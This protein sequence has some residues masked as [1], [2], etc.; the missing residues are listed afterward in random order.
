LRHTPNIQIGDTNQATMKTLRLAILV[1]LVGLAHT[2]AADTTPQPLPFSQS[3][4]STSQITTDD[5][6]S[7]VAGITGYRGDAAGTGVVDP[8]A[9]LE[10]RSATIDVNANQT[11]PDSFTTGGVT[12]FEAG[13][14]VASS[15]IALTG[16]GNADAPHI[17]V[18]LDTTGVVGV[19]VQYDILDLE[20]GDSAAQ[21]VALQYRVG[22]TGSF[23]NVPGGLVADATDPV[24]A[25][26]VT[27]VNVVLPAAADNQAN[28]QLRIMT[29]NATGNDEWVGIDNLSITNSSTPP[30]ATGQSTPGSTLAGGSVTLTALTAPGETPASTGIAVACDLTAIGGSATQ[31]LFDDGS[32]GDVLAADG[33][34]TFSATVGGTIAAGDKSLGCTVSDAQSRSSTFAIAVTVDAFCGDGRVEGTEACD[35]DDNDPADGCGPTCAVE[36]GWACTGSPSVCTDANECALGTDDCDPN[37]TCGDITGGFTCTC[38]AGYSGSGQVCADLDECALALD[39]CVSLS[40]CQNIGGSY[41]CECDEGYGGDGHAAGTACSDID[42][43][44][45]GADDCSND[46]DCSNGIGTFSC[47]CHTG[48]TG[49]GVT[50]VDDDECTLGSDTCDT[51]ATCTNTPG[52]FDCDCNTGYAGTGQVCTNVDECDL[53]TDTCDDNASC[54]DSVGSY[55]CV[56]DTGFSGD[57]T[58]C[59][60]ICGDSMILDTEQCD[61]GGSEDADGCDADCQIE[62]GWDCG[63]D[64]PSLCAELCGDGLVVGGEECDD[65]GPDTGDGCDDGCVV[66]DGWMCTGEP[67]TCSESALCGDGTIDAGEVCDDGNENDDDGCDTVCTVETGWVCAGEPS[68]CLTDSDDDGIAD[69]VDVCPAVADPDQADADDDGVGDACDETIEPD[70]GC[71]STSP[72]G[73]SGAALLALMT[74]VAIRRRRRT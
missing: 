55:A 73:G 17:V 35:D 9:V 3:W 32:N 49:D 27:H 44:A 8:S 61:D 40:T 39:D 71:C 41:T 64:E 69:T 19:R 5:S 45:T 43:C 24:T 4:T 52:T 51:N 70:G 1:V 56:C 65:A 62:A 57:G 48:F 66:E 22:S 74:L 54:T 13:A 15:T 26:K 12:E 58:T 25:T 2:A 10:D 34:F 50:C 14:A 30:T 60:A 20:T 11:T 68:D 36:T 16:S 29:G 37:A 47:T 59:A 7:G 6:W 28:L 18:Y 33:T 46:A 72:H 63:T 21:P 23:A 38:N 53:G 42:E 31:T 67:S